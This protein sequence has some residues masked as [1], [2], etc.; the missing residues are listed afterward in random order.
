MNEFNGV[1]RDQARTWLTVDEAFLL[2]Q[3]SELN[4]TKKTIR[5]WCRQEHVES[6]KQTTPT[7]ERWMV[8]KASLLVKIR[9]ELEFQRHAEPV[10]TA[11]N[12]LEL[13]RTAD[14]PV[15]TAA[16][17]SERVRTGSEKSEPVFG[18]NNAS[19]DRIAE[20]EGKVRSLE[21]DKAVRDRH[22]EF[23]SKQNEEGRNELLGQSR[24]I[25]HLE[26][27]LHRLGGR[28]DHSFLKPPVASESIDQAHLAASMPDPRQQQLDVDEHASNPPF[29]VI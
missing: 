4:R 12:Q 14:V 2:C 17:M 23:L 24:Y 18:D 6:Q 21:I 25:G 5:S 7:G 15:R 29:G 20:L 16:N 1:D 3:Q 10:R 28:P 9:N 27:Q 26:T 13:V 22:V 19:A 8:E 11:V